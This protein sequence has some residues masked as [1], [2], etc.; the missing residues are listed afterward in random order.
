VQSLHQGIILL[1]FGPGA[2]HKGAS[3]ATA[4]RRQLENLRRRPVKFS[5]VDL[6]PGKRATIVIRQLDATPP[7]RRR[8]AASTPHRRRNDAATPQRRL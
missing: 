2:D 5:T 4:T 1:W 6:R 8:N 3:R 7:Q